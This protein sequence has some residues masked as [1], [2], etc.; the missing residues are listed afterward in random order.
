M[1]NDRSPESQHAQKGVFFFFFFFF[2]NNLGLVAPKKIR[3]SAGFSKIHLNGQIWPRYS[4]S[5]EML[6]LSSLSVSLMMI[7][8]TV[9]SLLCPQYFLYYKSQAMGKLF[10]AQCY[11]TLMQIVRSGPQSSKILCLSA[12][13]A[14]LNKI[15]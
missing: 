10:D 15:R 13:A 14:S 11:V 5:S 6:R 9:K 7:R 12:L 3:S 2:F 1:G 4:Y 8:S